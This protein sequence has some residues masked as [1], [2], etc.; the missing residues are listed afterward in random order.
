M[1]FDDEIFD[2]PVRQAASSDPDFAAWLDDV[3]EAFE[4]TGEQ[5]LEMWQQTLTELYQGRATV[6]EA[7]AFLQMGVN[8]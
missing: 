5:M 6:A 4:A 1:Y 3:G 7:V 8:L 2:E